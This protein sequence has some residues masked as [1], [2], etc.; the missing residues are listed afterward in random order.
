[1]LGRMRDAFHKV[2]SLTRR[3]S[4]RLSRHP[5]PEGEGT[6]DTFL[7]FLCK[8]RREQEWHIAER[9]VGTTRRRA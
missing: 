8:A 6:F 7:D 2:R 1:M 4:L 3:A 9:V 5:L